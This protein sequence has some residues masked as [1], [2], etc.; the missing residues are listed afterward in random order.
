MSGIFSHAVHEKHKLS[1]SDN[2][3]AATLAVEADEVGQH[4]KRLERSHELAR[5]NGGGK[6]R[7]VPATPDAAP[8]DGRRAA[9][10]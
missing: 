3:K 9:T 8:Y 1:R 7:I 2:L 6:I 4:I 10:F 5:G